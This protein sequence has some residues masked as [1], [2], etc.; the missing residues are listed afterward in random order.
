MHRGTSIHP[1]THAWPPF[2]L[3]GL[4]LLGEA[5]RRA[6][7]EAD[8]GDAAA[9][10]AGY[11]VAH[12]AGTARDGSPQRAALA[13]WYPS[14]SAEA[15]VRYHEGRFAEGSAAVN[16]EPAAANGPFP[17]VLFSHGYAGSGVALVYLTEHLARN[18]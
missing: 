6:R 5:A 12:F 15:P 8:E 3:T 2:M 10:A 17:L 14:T 18:G 1:A 9:W 16:G 4:P 11:Q 13:V 7:T